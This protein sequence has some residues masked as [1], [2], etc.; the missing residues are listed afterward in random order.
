MNRLVLLF[1]IGVFA[2]G[3]AKEEDSGLKDYSSLNETDLISAMNKINESLR[4]NISA[5]N[6]YLERSL[7]FQAGGDLQS[8][9]A[10]IDRAIKLNPK[11]PS[12]Y[13]QQGELFLRMK[14][15]RQAELAFQTAAK[16]DEENVSSRLKLSEYYFYARRLQ[17]AM[18]MANEALRIDVYNDEAYFLKG[19]I[20]QNSGDTALAIS[21]YQTCVEQNPDYFEAYF[22]LGILSA[23]QKNRLAIDYYDNAIRIKPRDVQTYYN[24]GL[25]SQEL[26]EYNLALKTYTELLSIDPNYRDAHFAMGYVNMFY[27]KQYN[28]ASIHFTRAIEVSPDYYQ[29]Y[30][31]RGYCYELL[32]DVKRAEI[33]YR[34]ALKIKPDYSLAAEGMSRVTNF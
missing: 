34:N 26:G 30:Y 5:D 23:F 8:A 33:D 6:L 29:A 11:V 24:K 4:K 7:I 27:L 3:Q 20:H 25:I 16:L 31:N 19:L 21:S 9:M 10:D 14:N 18:D 28:Q 1:L 2:C 13:I 12:F 22:Q 17:E 15:F 32:G